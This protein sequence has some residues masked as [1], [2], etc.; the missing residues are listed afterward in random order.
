[1]SDMRL[2][3]SQIETNFNRI[4]SLNKFRGKLKPKAEL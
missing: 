2:K 1:M 4:G 3:D